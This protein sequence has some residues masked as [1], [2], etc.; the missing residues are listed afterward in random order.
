M[1]A[2]NN[3]QAKQMGAPGEVEEVVVKAAQNPR[4]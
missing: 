3:G 2:V 1:V 4:S